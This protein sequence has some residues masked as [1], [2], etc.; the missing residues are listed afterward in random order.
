MISLLP[1]TDTSFSRAI[2]RIMP[3]TEASEVPTPS[4][5]GRR[6]ISSVSE[7]AVTLTACS[8]R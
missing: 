4:P 2:L 1:V 6:F 3:P 7:L 8:S 5:F